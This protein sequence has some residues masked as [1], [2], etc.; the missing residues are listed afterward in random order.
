MGQSAWR[1]AHGA[2][3]MA[4]GAEGMAQSAWAGEKRRVHG[5]KRMAHGAKGTSRIP[6]SSNGTQ[7]VGVTLIVT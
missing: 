3:G 2:E 5:A 1:R 4:H 6:L 7:M